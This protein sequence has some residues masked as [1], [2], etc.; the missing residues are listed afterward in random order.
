MRFDCVVGLRRSPVGRE[1]LNF[2]REG[3]C[4]KECDPG[5]KGERRW[6]T[7]IGF[8]LDLRRD[9]SFS[10]TGGKRCDW[11]WIHSHCEWVGDILES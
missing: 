5:E 4:L 6:S 7:F 8:A 3:G 2:R 1:S 11:V 9:N 10:E